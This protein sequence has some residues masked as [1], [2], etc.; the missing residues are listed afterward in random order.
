MKRITLNLLVAAFFL[1]STNIYAGIVDVRFSDATLT[2]DSYCVNVQVKAQDIDFELGSATVFFNYNADAIA[3]PQS[4]AINFS[5]TNSCAFEGA[6]APYKN[7]FNYL[8]TDAKGEGNYAIL[9]MMPNAGCPTVSTEWVDVSQ[10][11][12][13]VVN[14]DADVELEI[15]AKYTAFNTVAN[16][17]TQLEVGNLLSLSGNVSEGESSAATP[18][19]GFAVAPNVTGNSVKVEY[20]VPAEASVSIVVYDMMGRTLISQNN[21]MAAGV[22]Q[23][24]LDLSKFG[25]GYYLIELNNGVTTSTEK[26]ALVK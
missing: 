5:E 17:G 14:P 3:N 23:A 2:D 18:F 11:C 16:D 21:T 9:L 24:D 25:D 15:N 13:D 6:M 10:F 8:Q 19:S 22:H 20:E 12:F 26:I 7:S 1:I 4:T